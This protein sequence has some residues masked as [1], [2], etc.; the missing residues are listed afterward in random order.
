MEPHCPI[1]RVLPSKGG[2]SHSGSRGRFLGG[3]YRNSEN[4][5]DRLYPYG[6]RLYMAGA[7]GN[8]LGILC[9]IYDYHARL[10][11]GGLACHNRYGE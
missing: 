6:T 10:R 1:R 5:V 7:G 11:P 2:G 4:G 9:V 3:S 8:S